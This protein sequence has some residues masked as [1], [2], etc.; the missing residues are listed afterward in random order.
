MKKT[1][2]V[3]LLSICSYPI[4]SNI[5][6]TCPEDKTVHVFELDTDFD[7]YGEPEVDSQE[8]FTLDRE[9]E[10][11]HNACDERYALLNYTAISQS[12]ETSSC[13][14]RIDIEKAE[15]TDVSLPM[16]VDFDGISLEEAQNDKQG[17]PFQYE[18][19]RGPTNIAASYADQVIYP[20]SGGSTL[21]ILRQGTFLDWCTAEILEH[22]QIIRILNFVQTQDF[23][24][25]SVESCYGKHIEISD[26]EVTTDQSNFQID[27]SNCPNT[28][29]DYISFVNCI[30]E[31]NDI[32]ED[33]HFQF[34]F[35]GPEEYL[36]GV[37]TLDIVLAQRHILA[38]DPFTE[39]CE[40][41]AADVNSDGWVTALDLV[42]IR[43]LILGISLGFDKSP[44]WKI[45]NSKIF[46][47]TLDDEE[48][49][50]LFRKNEF[51]LTDLDLKAIKIGDVNGTAN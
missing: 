41:I 17:F 4:F 38:I 34:N 10:Q 14:Q 2:I 33:K 47:E 48:R 30:A 24:L 29:A 21:K 6:I 45:V 19:L 42:L 43:R 8:N 44:A 25:F 46:D 22:N 26:V 15:L 20:S 1:L 31:A 50:L 13:V 27:Y 7:S 12:G 37:S 40:T 35:I 9:I 36:N 16:D 18:L 51:P 23:P 11:V 39:Y 28:S 49:D 5:T 3:F 32:D